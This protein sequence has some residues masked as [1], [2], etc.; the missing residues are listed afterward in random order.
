MITMGQALVGLCGLLA[1]APK[2]TKISGPPG[3]SI[4]L[5]SCIPNAALIELRQGNRIFRANTH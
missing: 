5:T 2:F 4:R 1:D 3:E